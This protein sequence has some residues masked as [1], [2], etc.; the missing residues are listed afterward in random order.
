MSLDEVQ[1]TG[2]CRWPSG[3]HKHFR[4]CGARRRNAHL[5][6]SSDPLPYCEAHTRM[7]L[8]PEWHRHLAKVKD[9]A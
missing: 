8:A 3:P 1:E 9:V 7:A 5:A 4:Y 2:G 6:F